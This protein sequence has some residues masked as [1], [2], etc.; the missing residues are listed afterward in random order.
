MDN[1]ESD[2][3][4]TILLQDVLCKTGR[5]LIKMKA[6]DAGTGARFRRKIKGIPGLLVKGHR[7]VTGNWTHKVGLQNN[8]L[9]GYVEIFLELTEFATE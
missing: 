7:W 9:S 2:L 6:W 5:K 3:Q 4:S 1:E 8:H